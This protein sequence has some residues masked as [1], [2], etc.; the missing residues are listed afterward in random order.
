MDDKHSTSSAPV[1]LITGGARRIGAE[2]A[3]QL[4]A[5]G[6]H[7]LIHYRDSATDANELCAQLNQ[8]RAQSAQ[9]IKADLALTEEVAALAQ[10][11]ESVWQ[12]LDLLV[13]NA[14][15]FY[16]TP[17]GKITDEAWDDLMASNLKAPLFLS[18]ALAPAL[19]KA[20]GCIINLADIHALR[21][22][23][24]HSVYCAAKAAN[25]MLTRSLALELAPEV[26]VNA[27][28]PGA[29]LWPEQNPAASESI[30]SHIPLGR[31]GS[32]ADIAQALLY[33]TEARY[34]TGQ[35]IAVDGGRS[36]FQ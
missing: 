7:L 8:T 32:P 13:N 19:K 24:D 10:A 31:C 25:L 26:R 34:V 14:S 20:G 4:H 23:K 9:A 11:A 1:A 35:M 28:A 17:L 29:I 5:K 6:Y 33:L 22:L 15:A 36:L 3:R 12:R 16:P 2:I 18:Q 27:I 21:P 30:F